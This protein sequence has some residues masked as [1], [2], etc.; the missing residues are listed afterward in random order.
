MP[1]IQLFILFSLLTAIIEIWEEQ[2]NDD[3]YQNREW[4]N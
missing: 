3:T 4:P 1:I 2:A